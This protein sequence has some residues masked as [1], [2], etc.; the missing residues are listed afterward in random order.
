MSTIQG[1]QIRPG[2]DLR[3]ILIIT[4][5]NRWPLQD[6]KHTRMYIVVP[7]IV[8]QMLDSDG[9]IGIE[10]CL[11]M[12][13]LAVPSVKSALAQRIFKSH[14]QFFLRGTNPRR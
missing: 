3:I 1:V 9:N 12:E 10:L 11:M 6:M 7:R 5:I 13:V 14:G 4:G 2:P 8:C